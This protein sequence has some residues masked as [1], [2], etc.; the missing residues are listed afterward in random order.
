[1]SLTS[2]AGLGRFVRR[3]EE[4]SA[5]LA[6]TVLA[7]L[8][9][10]V[11]VADAAGRV[12]LFNGAAER[13]YGVAA[14]DVAGR[15]VADVL[16]LPDAADHWPSDPEAVQLA[17]G[18]LLL[19]RH[20]HRRAD[21]T[22]FEAEVSL[23]PVR[24]PDG[25]VAG[26]AGVVRDVTALRAQQA[27][28]AALHAIFDASAEAIVGVDEH[29]VVR[30][31]SPAA[32]RLYG[33]RADAVVGGSI[34]QLTGDHPRLQARDLRADVHAGRT[35]H[36]ETVIRRD[37]GGRVAVHLTG[38]PIIGPDGTYGGAVITGLDISIRRRAE[39]EAT[40]AR[41]LLQ[42]VVD[43]APNVVWFKDREGRCRLVNRQGAAALGRKPEAVVGCT[44]VELFGPTAGARIR[45]EDRQV[46][47]SGVPMTFAK[48]VPIRGGGTRS[49]LMTK[50]PIPG[51]DDAPDGV[52][53]VASDISVLRRGE[54]DSARLAALV[55]AAPEAI[56]TED[57]DATIATWNPGAERMFGLPAA[58]A[59]GRPYDDVVVPPGERDAYRALRT[60]VLAGQTV[61]VRMG[62]RRADGSIF[63]TEVSTAA[64][65]A[66]DGSRTGAVAI[67]RDITELTE[68]ELDLRERAGQLERSNADLEEFA[69]AASHDLQ[70]PLRS[71][72]MG[73]ETLLHAA[74]GRLDEE[75]RALLAHVDAAAARMSA[76]VAALMDLAQVALGE[77]PD[78]LVP[79]QLPLDDA[80]DGLRAAIGEAGAVI[81]VRGTLPCA[82][83]PRA[84]LTLVLQNLLANA[85][86]YRR[87]G[88]RPRI[89]LSG[90]VAGDHVEV[91]I[92]DDGIGLAET[93]HSHIFTIFGR[94]HPG[95]SGTGMGLALCRRILERR[96]GSISVVSAG[97][98]KGSEFI[99]RLPAGRRA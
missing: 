37:D 5:E 61:T 15:H 74:A 97:P 44:D 64:L 11:V 50:F 12:V 6:A 16:V 39:R 90:A 19:A 52:G 89:T 3:R 24:D 72:K 35:V 96:S 8:S 95:A 71:I 81:E 86:K 29:D 26:V 13:L 73:A 47:E 48:D 70:E 34:W 30:F 53:V 38:S 98:G 91:R 4:V 57:A 7:G 42:R 54:A 9:E 76:Q 78:T 10:A 85:I 94:A 75:E 32:E 99:L 66:A 93:D 22:V 65:T 80:L 28:A 58:E 77:G 18:P 27:G 59:V 25:T 36:R 33:R 82:A 49:Y 88:Q 69:Y 83:V 17:G 87:P 40:R 31:F 20:R 2:R 23:S 43:H 14:A 68:T 63:P 92:A 84:E 62:G 60:R 41:E 45:A 56:I 1:V 55:R 21:G 79:V 51:G 67:V 46:M